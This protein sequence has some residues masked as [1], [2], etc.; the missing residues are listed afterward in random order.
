MILLGITNRAG[1]A[2]LRSASRSGACIG[3]ADLRCP[4]QLHLPARPACAL[5]RLGPLIKFVFKINKNQC[6][7]VLGPLPVSRDCGSLASSRARCWP[8]FVP[9]FIEP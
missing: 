8:G 2:R 6:H 9:G 5:Q 1:A 4:G 7:T 3:R